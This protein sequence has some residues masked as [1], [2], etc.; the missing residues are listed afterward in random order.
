M[1][2]SYSSVYWKIR[3]P[4][5]ETLSAHPLSPVLVIMALSVYPEMQAVMEMEEKLNWDESGGKL[6]NVEKF[7]SCI[8][9][10]KSFLV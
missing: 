8:N 1:Q 6:C 2:V 5:K 10:C 7:T 9:A 3:N 4:H